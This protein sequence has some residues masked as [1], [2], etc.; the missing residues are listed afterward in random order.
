M[1]GGDGVEAGGVLNDSSKGVQVKKKVQHPVYY[2]SE[3]L[4]DS[5]V[6]Y[7]LVQKLLYTLLITSRKLQHYFQAHKIQVV[8]NSPLGE[9]LCNRDINGRVV[10]WS[11]ELGEFDITFFQNRMGRT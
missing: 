5:K 10:K 9:I 11:M 4:N 3:V 2:V 1:V 7:A 6:C 8:C